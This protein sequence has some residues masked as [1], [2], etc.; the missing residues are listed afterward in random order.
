M[1][2]AMQLDSSPGIVSSVI[3]GSASPKSALDSATIASRISVG[4]D[5]KLGATVSAFA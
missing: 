5:A 1:R 2:P 3:G 4:S